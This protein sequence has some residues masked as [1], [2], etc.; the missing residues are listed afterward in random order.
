MMTFQSQRNHELGC[1]SVMRE[2]PRRGETGTDENINAL[3]SKCRGNRNRTKVAS[4]DCKHGVDVIAEMVNHLL[5]NQH[6]EQLLAKCL[7][8]CGCEQGI[9]IEQQKVV[10]MLIRSS[11]S[12]K[13]LASEIEEGSKLYFNCEFLN[14]VVEGG[15][16]VF[17]QYILW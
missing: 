8:K 3:I 11:F 13:W 6:E 17:I 7:T 1:P 4:F 12:S 14:V 9:P 2:D 5:P 10:K 16:F 15:F